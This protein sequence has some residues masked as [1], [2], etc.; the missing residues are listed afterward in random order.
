MGELYV[1]CILNLFLANQQVGMSYEDIFVVIII[2]CVPLI[3]FYVSF[4]ILV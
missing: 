2:L 4:I 1:L 3:L